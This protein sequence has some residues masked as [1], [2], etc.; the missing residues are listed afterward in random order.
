MGERGRWEFRRTKLFRDRRSPLQREEPPPQDGRR[1]G[2]SF[3]SP[4]GAEDEGG[5]GGEGDAGEKAGGVAFGLA[6]EGL[7][8][9][10][11]EVVFVGVVFEE[12]EG[13]EGAVVADGVAPVEIGFV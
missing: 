9:C 8:R 11:G 6:S 3:F 13:V 4:G 10:F 7:G 12:E 1:G 2:S 5:Q